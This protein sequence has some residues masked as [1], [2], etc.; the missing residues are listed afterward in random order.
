MATHTET[1][2]HDVA[3]GAGAGV[4]GALVKDQFQKL[5]SQ[6]PGQ[7]GSG[8]G[9]EPSTWEETPAPAKIGRRVI[10]GVFQREVPF[11]QH[12]KVMWATH[13][14]YG[15]AWGALYGVVEASV[16]PR[17]LAHGLALGATVWGAAYVLLP[18]AKLYKPVWKYPPRTLAKDLSYHL[19]YGLGVA[20]AFAASR[21][22]LRS[23]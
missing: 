15:A 8:E 16:R 22:L 13:L 17:T 19:V 1:P 20:L 21:R 23:S 7:D 6:A 5:V 12:D 9:Q 3:L 2:L 18:A 14:G 10:E 4:A 11:E